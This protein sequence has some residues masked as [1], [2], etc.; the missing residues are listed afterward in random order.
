M[1]YSY[2][3][4]HFSRLFINGN[5]SSTIR[6]IS[7]NTNPL[8]FQTTNILRAEPL[9][10]KK[11]LDPA[12]IKQR[13]EKR[14]KKL[15]K[16]I[17]KLEKV[18]LQL[19]PIDECEVPLKL[20]DGKEERIRKQLILNDEV[21]EERELLKKTWCAYKYHQ[22]LSLVQMIDS[23]LSSQQKALDELR[24]ESEELYM[25][26]IQPD[27]DLLPYIA[28]GPVSTPPI[29]NYPSPDGEYENISKTWD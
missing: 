6:H 7:T 8:F 10:K 29:K 19:K 22:Q 3:L 13:E 24:M 25:E 5:S 27:I 17:R 14:R 21:I 20:I 4:S 23:V 11:R 15:E 2:F 16:Q 28:K 1:S 18:A 26:A 9:K 12:I